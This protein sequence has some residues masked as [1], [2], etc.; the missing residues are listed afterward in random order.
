MLGD[1]DRRMELQRCDMGI[2]HVD[3]CHRQQTWSVPDQYV[4]MRYI[5]V[6]RRRAQMIPTL[7]CLGLITL[8]PSPER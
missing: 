2:V 3:L 5:G 6:R 7:V 8:T 1:S 4:I